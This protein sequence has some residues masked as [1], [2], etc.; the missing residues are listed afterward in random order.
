MSIYYCT[1]A[2]VLT[3]RLFLLADIWGTNTAFTRFAY[4]PRGYPRPVDTWNT[5]TGTRNRHPATGAAAVD[6]IPNTDTRGGR[7]IPMQGN[8]N[9]VSG[10]INTDGGNGSRATDT[11]A[12]RGFYCVQGLYIQ[13]TATGAT[14]AIFQ[15]Y[16]VQRLQ[17]Y[18]FRRGA[19]PG[20]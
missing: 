9:A 13:C 19:V 15:R 5:T 17:R 4:T 11:T 16:G 14:G 18:Q 12:G 3:E 7:C 1:R 10:A 8:K 2:T 6:I 20:L